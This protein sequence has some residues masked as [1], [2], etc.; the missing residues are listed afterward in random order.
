MRRVFWPALALALVYTAV[1]TGLLV[2]L[3]RDRDP[4]AVTAAWLI[5]GAPWIWSGV[6][7][8]VIGWRFH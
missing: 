8:R 4:E 7:G 2:G 6:L 3:S 1:A 5:I